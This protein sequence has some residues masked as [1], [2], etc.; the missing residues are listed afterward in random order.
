MSGRWS[1][2]GNGDANLQQRLPF[3]NADAVDAE[4][5]NTQSSGSLRSRLVPGTRP[6]SIGGS[7]LSSS[8]GQRQPARSFFHYA[9]HGHADPLQY[10][11]PGVREQTQELA[12]WALGDSPSHRRLSIGH[13]EASATGSERRGRRRTISTMSEAES[14]GPR[15]STDSTR[16]EAIV[17]VSEPASPEDTEDGDATDPRQHASALSSMIRDT[18]SQKRGQYLSIASPERDDDDDSHS[19]VSIV[20]DD[21]DTGEVT[22]TS[23]LLPR[24]RLPPPKRA[25][26]YKDPGFAEQQKANLSKRWNWLKFAT[27]DVMSTAMNPKEWDVKQ[28]SSAAVGAVAAVFLGLLLNILDALSYGMILFPLGEEIFEKT[29]PDGISMFYVSCIVSQLVYSFGGSR[30][31]GGVGSEMI[32]V[33]PFFHKMAYMVLGRVGADKPE[34]VMAT[35]ITSYALSSILTGLIFLILSVL[36]LGDLVS[37]FPRSILLGC[38]GG[39]GVFLFLTGIEVSAGLDSNMEWNLDVFERLIAPRTLVLWIIPLALSILLMVIRHYL[40][41]PTVMPAFFI[42]VVGI[43]Y[44]VFAALPNVS[45]LDLQNN[46]WVFAAPEAGVPFY[47]FYTYYSKS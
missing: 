14:D 11:S 40:S 12:N 27:K 3:T 34:A 28:A 17:E 21:Y 37:F 32:E 31:K 30:F 47:N 6:Q 19:E 4:E 16:P 46:G 10:A 15:T 35:V 36:R 9:S 42:C 8:V 20:V 45:L 39:V 41:H 25:H 29:G 44:I 1:R 5:V 43:F 23:N 24:A 7:Y 33:V 26:R 22:E 13:D 38:I 2:R 18:R